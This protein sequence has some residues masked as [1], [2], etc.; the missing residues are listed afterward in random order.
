MNDASESSFVACVK[1]VENHEPRLM[2]NRYVLTPAAKARAL[3]SGLIKS[4]A[5][6][7]PDND[8]A[9]AVKG[10]SRLACREAKAA[11]MKALHDGRV[12]R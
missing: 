10:K 8:F 9:N 1:L 2:E 12:E 4:I 11:A 7:M 5:P 3:A 6:S